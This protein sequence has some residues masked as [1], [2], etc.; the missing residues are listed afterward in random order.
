MRDFVRL[1]RGEE[2]QDDLT[3]LEDSLESHIVAFAAEESRQ[4]QQVVDIQKWR[5]THS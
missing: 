2:L 4:K 5:A 3:Y 1:L